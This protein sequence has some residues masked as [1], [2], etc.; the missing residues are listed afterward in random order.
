LEQIFQRMY[1]SF[2]TYRIT[3]YFIVILLKKLIKNGNFVDNISTKNNR[4]K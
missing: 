3:I 1:S 2:S 4:E